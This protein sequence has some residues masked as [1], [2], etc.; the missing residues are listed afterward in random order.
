MRIR[1]GSWCFEIKSVL[2]FFVS[3][4]VL[5]WI[6]NLNIQNFPDY[7]SYYNYFY[8][9]QLGYFWSRW[10]TIHNIFLNILHLF[11]GEILWAL[12]T[13]SL[14]LCMVP[15]AA[16]MFTTLLSNALLL[17]SVYKLKNPFLA[18][19]LWIILPVA[20]ATVGV[21]Q[22]RQ[23]FAFA[24]FMFM[25]L[26]LSRPLLGALLAAMIHTTFF[27]PLCFLG[28]YFLFKKNKNYLVFF[29]LFLSIAMATIGDIYFAE[30]AGR[31]VAYSVNGDVYNINYVIGIVLISVPTLMAM[32]KNKEWSYLLIMHFGLFVWAL[33]CL[34]EFKIGNSRVG[35]YQG[36]FLIPLI[37]VWRRDRWS[38]AY[39]MFVMTPFLLKTIY[40]A[41]LF[42]VYHTLGS[43]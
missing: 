17:F 26:V 10:L 23:G 36:L 43:F 32:Y 3:I 8:F 25:A 5:F 40:T 20:M 42:G 12:Y 18:L 2:F 7:P 13:D 11:T 27:I 38:L 1:V 24:I 4:F 41:W 6:F 14:K 21:M 31:R 19:L 22:I 29:I 39:Y 35:Y 33:V 15:S 30:I 28:L 37:Q 34:A 16:V 9:N